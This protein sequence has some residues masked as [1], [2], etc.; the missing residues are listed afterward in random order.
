LQTNDFSESVTA[1]YLG[2]DKTQN[3]WF[4]F[5]VCECNEERLGRSSNVNSVMIT[6]EQAPDKMQQVTTSL[7]NC[8]VRISWETPA[9]N[10]SP[11][12]N[13]I[14]EVQNIDH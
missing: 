7:E 3:Q 10:G 9:E 14:L 5:Y 6:R 11:I 12:D 8:Q 2:A 1:T 4:T 13:Y